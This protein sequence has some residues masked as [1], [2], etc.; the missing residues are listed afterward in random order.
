MNLIQ[1]IGS[2]SGNIKSI[3]NLMLENFESNIRNTDKLKSLINDSAAEAE[4][5]STFINKLKEISK[6]TNGSVYQRLEYISVKNI[7]EEAKLKVTDSDT[8]S[9]ELIVDAGF[10]IY[11]NRYH[12]IDIFK[13]IML[14]SKSRASERKVKLKVTTKLDLEKKYVEIVFHDDGRYLNELQQTKIFDLFYNQHPDEEKMVSLS[15]VKH[16]V[17]MYNGELT[18]QSAKRVGVKIS[19]LFKDILP[20]RTFLET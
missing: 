8:F 1:E 20:R 5:V 15:M 7:F 4:K 3:M 2:P 17:N 19:L 10:E 13:Q 16:T 18:L 9:S 14:Q 12:F 6:I 11:V